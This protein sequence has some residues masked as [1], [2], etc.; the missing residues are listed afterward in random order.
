VGSEDWIVVSISRAIEIPTSSAAKS[1]DTST[2]FF[3]LFLWF[4][5][6]PSDCA[7]SHQTP[8]NFRRF[9]QITVLDIVVL[10]M[11]NMI[12]FELSCIIGTSEW[13]AVWMIRWNPVQSPG[14]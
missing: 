11:D 13:H 6:R 7:F 14:C 1:P 2:I 3:L 5:R 9:F 12:R 4:I 10:I 8:G